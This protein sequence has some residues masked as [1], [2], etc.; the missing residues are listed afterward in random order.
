MPELI[1]SDRIDGNPVTWRCSQCNHKFS[2]AGKLTMQERRRRV[3]A[4]F[5][6]H[7]RQTH[8]SG[9][10]VA[11]TDRGPGADLGKVAHTKVD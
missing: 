7:L 8:A 11:G 9:E 4:E 3:N 5:K 2:V 6:A 10:A 1:V